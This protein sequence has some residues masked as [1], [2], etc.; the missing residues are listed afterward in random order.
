MGKVLRGQGTHQQWTVANDLK[1]AYWDRVHTVKHDSKHRQLTKEQRAKLGTLKEALPKAVLIAGMTQRRGTLGL[2]QQATGSSVENRIK[3]V[4][5]RTHNLGLTEGS[6]V[7][8]IQWFMMMLGQWLNEWPMLASLAKTNPEGA[9]MFTRRRDYY[10]DAHIGI[11][12]GSA[13]G[14]PKNMYSTIT[15]NQE[16]VDA[17]L[18]YLRQLYKKL[19]PLADLHE[20]TRKAQY[21]ASTHQSNIKAMKSYAERITELEEVRDEW[22]R[23][24]TEVIKWLK[25]RPECI[26]GGRVDFKVND[27]AQKERALLHLLQRQSWEWQMARAKKMSAYYTKQVEEYN[28]DTTTD[29]ID[30][31]AVKK[32]ISSI[33]E[34]AVKWACTY[35]HDFTADGGEE[36]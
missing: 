15:I 6:G 14:M 16:M 32:A 30:H 34:E 9:R 18:A 33:M 21:G 3:W 7:G 36:E 11:H 12:V 35:T 13:G 4:S 5:Q 29:M 17:D 22:V 10:E 28:P 1:Q 19:K 23:Q 27:D 20:Q 24:D 2:A 31:E 26:V 25:S 8:G